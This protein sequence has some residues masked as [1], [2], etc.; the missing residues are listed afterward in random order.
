MKKRKL[1]AEYDNTK[2]SQQISA[3]QIIIVDE[4]N[5]LHTN[6]DEELV[7]LNLTWDVLEQ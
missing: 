4:S 2:A 3:N 7:D 1:L 6:L 5:T